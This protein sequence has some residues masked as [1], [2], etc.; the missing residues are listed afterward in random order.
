MDGRQL[1]AV[2][3][4]TQSVGDRVL[5]PC[6]FHVCPGHAK[7]GNWEEA[8]TCGRNATKK[9]ACDHF[10]WTMDSLN[11]ANRADYVKPWLR[12]DAWQ[13]QAPE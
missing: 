11:G 3:Q 7:E 9:G 6:I 8:C 12:H 13:L 2:R 1:F 4:P 5:P 10:T